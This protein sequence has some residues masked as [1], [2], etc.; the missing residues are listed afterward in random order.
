MLA[1]TQRLSFSCVL[2]TKFGQ[3][4]GAG[5]QCVAVHHCEPEACPV[6]IYG[7]YAVT[8]TAY[9][10]ENGFTVPTNKKFGG[11]PSHL[12]RALAQRSLYCG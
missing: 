12:S 3:K 9:W 5:T 11:R 6:N 4:D 8:V 7:R 10:E 1:A 2:V